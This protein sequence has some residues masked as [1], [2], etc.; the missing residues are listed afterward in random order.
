MK[1]LRLPDVLERL[2]LSKASLYRLI[3]SGRFPAPV[4]MGGASRWFDTD[5]DGYLR[6]VTSARRASPPTSPSS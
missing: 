1:V 6:A 3:Q 4:K 2:N 5:V